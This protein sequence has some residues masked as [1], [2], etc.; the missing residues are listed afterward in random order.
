M[1]HYILTI[2]KKPQI[3]RLQEQDLEQIF[4]AP[5]DDHTI[6]RQDNFSILCWGDPACRDKDHLI[7]GDVLAGKH[8]AYWMRI[9]SMLTSTRTTHNAPSSIWKPLSATQA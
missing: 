1:A 2:H 8:K 9:A 6:I 5:V 4:D 7:I 3:H